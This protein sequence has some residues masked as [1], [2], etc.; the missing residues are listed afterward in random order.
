MASDSNIKKG[1]ALQGQSREIIYNVYKYFLNE[2]ELFKSNRESN[3]FKKI[4]DRVAEATGVSRRTLNRILNEIAKEDG[5]SPKFVTPKRGKKK[6][7][8][9]IPNPP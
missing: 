4:Q 2:A 8:E 9:K 3:Y 1:K 6:K 5:I 7:V